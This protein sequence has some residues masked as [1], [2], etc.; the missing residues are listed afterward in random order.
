[1]AEAVLRRLRE[2]GDEYN[3][4]DPQKLFQIAQRQG[5]AGATTALAKEALAQDVVGRS[6]ALL[7]GPQARRRP[8]GQTAPSRQT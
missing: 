5:V 8:R 2:L 1:M 7:P 6:C 4:R 3:L